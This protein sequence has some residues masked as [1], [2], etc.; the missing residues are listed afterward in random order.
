MVET[1]KPI[2]N[3]NRKR[4]FRIWDSS[5]LYDIMVKSAQIKQNIETISIKT[6]KELPEL[7]STD[8]PV[9]LLYEL[10]V[11]YQQ[12]YDKLLKEHLLVSANP[13]QHPLIH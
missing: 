4:A 1:R 11:G 9:E 8:V 2:L 5:F 7:G 13:K 10:C 12:M 3:K 6:N